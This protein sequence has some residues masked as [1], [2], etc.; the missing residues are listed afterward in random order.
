MLLRKFGAESD[1]ADAVA[2]LEQTPNAQ[3][4]QDALQEET[5]EAG[6]D[7]DAEIITEAEALLAAI[8]ALPGGKEAVQQIVSQQ[9]IGNENIFSGTG[10]VT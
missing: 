1:L 6:A 3:W 4:R 7:K 8:K 10:D 9:V 2:K 5:A